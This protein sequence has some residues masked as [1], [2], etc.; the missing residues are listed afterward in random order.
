MEKLTVC[1]L[2]F[3]KIN[4]MNVLILVNFLPGILQK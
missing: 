3:H 4:M 1:A 2:L